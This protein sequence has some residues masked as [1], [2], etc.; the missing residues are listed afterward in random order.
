MNFRFDEKFFFVETTYNFNK[1]NTTNIA[2]PA[3]IKNYKFNKELNIW[4]YIPDKE[5]WDIQQKYVNMAKEANA[6][7]SDLE[8]TTFDTQRTEWL[9][10]IQD[11]STN[12][13]AVDALALAR[14][15]SKE[16]LMNKIGV[17]VTNLMTLVGQQQ[18]EEDEY[19]ASLT[20]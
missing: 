19:K 11:N 6:K 16:E 12:T 5:I 18:K 8:I 2:P 13:P 7:F 9:Y 4:E 10:W 17:A 20:E 3:L 1:E 15:I 14:G